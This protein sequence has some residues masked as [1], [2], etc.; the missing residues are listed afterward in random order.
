MMEP[1]A[2]LLHSHLLVRYLIAALLLTGQAST[3]LASDPNYLLLGSTWGQQPNESLC[4]VNTATGLATPYVITDDQ[5]LNGIAYDEI[6]DKLYAAMNSGSFY[7]SRLV[8]VDRFSGDI[9]TYYNVGLYGFIEVPE[10]DVAVQ[11]STGEVFTLR[12]GGSVHVWN[13]VSKKFVRSFNLAESNDYSCIAFNAAGDLYV[14]NPNS[15]TADPPHLLRI[16]P[17]DGTILQTTVL[18]TDIGVVAGLAFHPLTDH[19]WLADG[20][21]GDDTCVGSR[22]FQVNLATGA[23]TLVG[24]TGLP[25]AGITFVPEVPAA[26]SGQIAMF[27]GAVDTAPPI[28]HNQ[29]IPVNFGTLARNSASSRPITLK[30]TGTNPLTIHRV[31]AL[32]S[33]SV[34]GLPALPAILAPG[35][36]TT[37]NLAIQT[38]GGGTYTGTLRIFSSDDSP[39]EANI[40]ITAQV[41]LLK[42]IR[43][44]GPFGEVTDGQLEPVV[45]QAGFVAAPSASFQVFNDGPESLTLSSLTIPAGFSVNVPDGPLP[46]TIASGQ[47]LSVNLTTTGPTSGAYSGVVTIFNDD[48]DE[49]EFTFPIF[50]LHNTPEIKVVTNFT[51]EVQSGFSLDFGNATFGRAVNRNVRIFN[52]YPSA[53]TIS[54]IT[55]PDGFAFVSTPTFPINLAQNRIRDIGIR[56]TATAAGNFNG[57]L[58]IHNND[59]DE[60][61]FELNLSGDVRQDSITFSGFSSQISEYPSPQVGAFAQGFNFGPVTYEWDLDGDGDYD[62]FTGQTVPLASADGPGDFAARVR[63]TDSRSSAVFTGTVP[64][65]NSVPSLS[66]SQPGSFAAGVQ[67]S[68][69]LTA[70]DAVPDVAAGFTWSIDWGDGTVET[71]NPGAAAIRAFNH[72]Y[73]QP[74]VQW[75]ITVTAT[76]KDGGIGQFN[77]SE[78]IHSG[79]IGVFD[80]PNLEGTQLRDGQDTLTFFTSLN[81]PEDHQIT[82]LN[83]SASPATI[84]PI[85]LP[86]GFI[87]VSPPTLPLVLAPAASATL[88]VRFPASAFGTFTGVLGIATSDP[89]MPIF[90]LNLSGEVE[91]PDITVN[92]FSVEAY[93]FSSGTRRFNVAPGIGEFEGLSINIQADGPPLT[94]SAIELPPGFQLQGPPVFPM[95]IDGGSENLRIQANGPN[96]SFRKGWVKIHSN[97]PDESVFSFLVTSRNGDLTDLMVVKSESASAFDSG[98]SVEGV[99]LHNLAEPLVFTT[100]GPSERGVTLFNLGSQSLSITGATLPVGFAFASAPAFPIEIGVFSNQALPAIQFTG[101]APGTYS[102]RLEITSS[103]P[104][105]NPYRIPLLA[106]VAGSAAT[107]PTYASAPV[108]VPAT[109]TTGAMF[110]ATITG[111][112]NASVS[113]EAST[114]LGQLDPWETLHTLQLDTNGAATFN[115]IADPGSTGASR[116]FWRLQY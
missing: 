34:S 104:D 32:G 98:S 113:L 72:T 92:Q 24:S 58:I 81:Q 30:N 57:S 84:G 15:R 26:G 112:P 68:F 67:T 11:K 102:G 79:V 36:T 109:A 94:I 108:I 82:L 99:I 95:V 18:G 52:L 105:E 1:L 10:G 59:Y 86:A 43:V 100:P 77:L 6:G 110:S 85:T 54:G 23:L 29:P 70:A 103:D 55:L 16:N 69:T 75:E 31:G 115:H 14:V 2:F 28:T 44:V 60:G 64:Y 42:E 73:A 3:L 9:S 91:A 17:S 74:G 96:P 93:D 45:F 78:W 33:Y 62:D 13:S 61:S 63:I 83:R 20:C 27:D 111:T 88:T 38:T 39:R 22:L 106:V 47:S 56:M 8:E 12:S 25:L 114:D 89:L 5:G 4:V 80:G 107:P 21:F 71:S 46:R 7:S 19:A 35:A 101:T 50:A 53:L 116:N 48:D 40:P 49:S 66:I 51:A 87:L 37:F 41:P 76:D 90:E 65:I 97:D